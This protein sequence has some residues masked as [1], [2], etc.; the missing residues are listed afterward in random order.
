MRTTRAQRGL[1]EPLWQPP[2]PNG[3]SDDS[4]AWLDGL[5]QRLVVANSFSQRVAESIDPAAVAEAALGQLAST[6][7]RDAIARAE[8]KSQAL[9]VLL[10]SPEFQR[11]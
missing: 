3:F 9:A 2:A 6:E 4:A 11:R 8:S 5:A 1:G 10:M 7:T